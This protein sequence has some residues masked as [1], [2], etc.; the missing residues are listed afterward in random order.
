MAIVFGIPN[1]SPRT[2]NRNKP[3]MW[4]EVLYFAHLIFIR[5]AITE[6]KLLSSRSLPTPPELPPSSPKAVLFLARASH[7]VDL[8]K[9]VKNRSSLAPQENVFDAHLVHCWLSW[10]LMCYRCFPFDPN[11]DPLRSREFILIARNGEILF[12]VEFVFQPCPKINGASF[13]LA[14]ILCVCM[15]MWFTFLIPTS[16]AIILD[17]SGMR[18]LKERTGE[19]QLSGERKVERRTCTRNMRA[20][21]TSAFVTRLRTRRSFLHNTRPSGDVKHCSNLT[22]RSFVLTNKEISHDLIFCVVFNL[23]ARFL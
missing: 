13:W 3:L 2:N 1:V 14:S 22:Q 16:R 11:R 18:L 23:A 15:C 10:C 6:R 7:H 5:T 20:C 9:I 19:R 12:V 21:H 8:P 4:I 17:Q